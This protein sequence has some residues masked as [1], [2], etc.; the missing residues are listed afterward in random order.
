MTSWPYNIFEGFTNKR[1][2]TGN[3]SLS[4]TAGRPLGSGSGQA[5]S[6]IAGQTVTGTTYGA[7]GLA[8]MPTQSSMNIGITSG[9]G[10][11]TGMLAGNKQQL[12]NSAGKPSSTSVHIS[13]SPNPKR[14]IGSNAKTAPMAKLSS[15]EHDSTKHLQSKRVKM[16]NISNKLEYNKLGNASMGYQGNQTPYMP[17]T[18]KMNLTMPMSSTMTG[19]KPGMTLPAMSNSSISTKM[20]ELGRK[21]AQNRV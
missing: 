11:Q 3:G 18:P 7:G 14:V 20:G 12:T 2:N 4:G 15:A 13:G 21:A 5:G 19:M 8:S 17:S 9:D 16:H 10:Q 6:Q 1:A